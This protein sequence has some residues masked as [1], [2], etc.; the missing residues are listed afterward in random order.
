M[1]C[2][3]REVGLAVKIGCIPPMELGTILKDI[4]VM[5]SMFISFDIV[6]RPRLC[7]VIAHK[8][9]RFSLRFISKATWTEIS[10]CVWQE[11]VSD[12]LRLR[13]H[14]L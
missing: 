10:P 9:A 13:S 11:I 8:L 1:Q 7:N 2:D 5:S 4:Q 6:F 14:S 3:C 12:Q